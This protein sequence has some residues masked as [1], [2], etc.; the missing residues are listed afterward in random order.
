MR[1]EIHHMGFCHSGKGNV[2][3]PALGGPAFSGLMICG[4]FML[5]TGC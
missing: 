2:P 3:D 4:W 5:P 1:K